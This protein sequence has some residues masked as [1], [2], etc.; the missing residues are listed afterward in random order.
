MSGLPFEGI[1]VVDA[2][3]VWAGPYVT[4]ILANMGAEVIKVEAIQH[5]D[6]WRTAGVARDLDHFW[7]QSPSFNAVNLN[8]LGITLDLHRPQGVDIFRRLVKISDIVAENYTPRVMKSFGLDYASLREINPGIIMISMP[9]HGMT[10]P[11]GEHPGYAQSIEQMSGIAYVTGPLDGPPQLTGWALT[12]PTAGLYG[13]SAVMLALLYRQA[14]G[15]GQ[16]ID[17]AQTEAMTCMIGDLI[18]DYTLNQRIATRRGNRH[19]FMSPHG[20]YR[21]RGEDC[22]L[23]IAVATDEEWHSLVNVMGSP[24][25][26]RDNRF[27]DALSRWQNQDELDTLLEEWTISQGHLQAMEL[28]QKAGVPA[29]AVLNGRELLADPQL[30]A[31]GTFIDVDRAL[32]GKHPYPRPL[33]PTK[34]SRLPEP[35]YRHTPFLGEH[36][37]LVLGKLL[38]FS[39]EEITALADEKIIG[40]YPTEV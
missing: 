6:S 27:A 29:G 31:R 14:T 40:N 33:A 22:W 21:C 39:K 8:K 30:Q 1:R 28:L 34:F 10:G 11:W 15:E 12:D 35:E 5:I 9:A 18:M 38:G 2:S 16:Y 13:A 3:M 36:N 4:N 24:A 7:E 17:L 32:V 26:A 20:C 23:T 19:P 25:W 37:E